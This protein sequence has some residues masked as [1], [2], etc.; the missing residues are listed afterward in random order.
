MAKA[1]VLIASKTNTDIAT[2][3]MNGRIG[4]WLL[5]FMAYIFFIALIRRSS[6]MAAANAE[7]LRFNA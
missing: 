3:A 1:G 5:Y 4:N 2:M 6:V 7:S